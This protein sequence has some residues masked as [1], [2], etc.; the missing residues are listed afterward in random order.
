MNIH[1]DAVIYLATHSCLRQNTHKQLTTN[2][3]NKKE[4]HKERDREK[5]ASENGADLSLSTSPIFFL[6]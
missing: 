4:R 3:N 2:R 6:F 5:H 1:P